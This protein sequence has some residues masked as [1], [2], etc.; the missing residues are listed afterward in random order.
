MHYTYS[1]WE[2][3]GPLPTAN[4]ISDMW[5]IEPVTDRGQLRD[6]QIKTWKPSSAPLKKQ[7]KTKH[8]GS[9]TF[10]CF[11]WDI[12]LCFKLAWRNSC[13]KLLLQTPGEFYQSFKPCF[14]F[15]V[16]WRGNR[17]GHQLLW[18][19]PGRRLL[20]KNPRVVCAALLWQQSPKNVAAVK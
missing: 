13:T 5:S 3:S 8:G 9:A 4:H 6:F 20:A 18:W 2:P 10:H 1:N 17:L 12:C 14:C 15:V 7:N 11:L 19:C 16:A